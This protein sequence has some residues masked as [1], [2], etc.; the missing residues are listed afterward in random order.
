MKVCFVGIGSI[1]KRH[2]KNITHVCQQEGTDLEIHVLRSSRTPLPPDI[3]GF[4]SREFFT[5]SEL[6]NGY[7]A[8][9]IT[10][11]TDM[12]YRTMQTVKDHS[13]NFFIEKPLFEDF[14]KDIDAMNLPAENRYY[15]AC[16]LRYT[17]VIAE[18]SKV[19]KAKPVFSVRAISSSYL[20]DWRP[21]VDYTKVYSASKEQGGGVCIDLIHEWDYLSSIFGF[22]RRIEM[23]AG[24]FS[25]LKI[26]SE[27]LAVYIADYGDKL[28]EVH[29]DYFGRRPVRY[30]EFLT[31]EGTYRFDIVNSKIIFNDAV[32]KEFN[33]DPNEKYIKEMRY[34]IDLISDKVENINNMQHAINVLKVTQGFQAL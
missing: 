13:R 33:E 26:T 15:I 24:K 25:D 28:V 7:D 12:H 4:I 3:Q 8:V 31:G 32:I 6:D 21:N 2:V 30:C 34:F 22:P 9:F 18:A 14:N 20:P 5:E 10:N 19:A 11:P 17:N 23:M 1:G 29:L 16:P 27:D